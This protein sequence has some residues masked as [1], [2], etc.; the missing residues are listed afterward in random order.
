MTRTRVK[1]LGHSIPARVGLAGL[2]SACLALYAL[3]GAVGVVLGRRSR[4]NGGPYH[5]LVVGT[6]YT[7]NWCISHLAPLAAARNVRRVTAI[8]EGPI[9]PIAN[10]D[11]VQP[12]GWP[13]RLGGRAFGKFCCAIRLALKHRPDVV[14]GYHIVPNALIALVAARAVGAAS[15]Y[16]MTAGPVELLGGGWATENVFVRHLRRPSLVIDRLIH[17]IARCFDLVIVRG[18]GAANYARTHRLGRAISTIPGSIDVRRFAP[19]GEKR[20]YDLVSVG[21][22]VSVKQPEQTLRVVAILKETFP[23]VR[24]IV[25]G[26]GPLLEPLKAQAQSLGLVENIEFAGH[27][28]DVERILKRSKIFLLTSRSEGLSIALAEAMSAGAVPVVARVGELGDLVRDGVNGWLVTPDA[29]AE[30]AERIRT[31]LDSPADLARCSAAAAN[32]AHEHNGLES[33]AE[34]WTRALADACGRPADCPSP[35]N[36]V[37]PVSLNPAAHK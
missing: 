9:Q 3:L 26:D 18:H 30:Y 29:I 10:V 37:G 24:A 17:A 20:E 23:S 36:T 11:Y 35:S 22:L 6:F 14:M 32:A 1:C 7:R 21:R 28:D 31:L 12:S 16:Q 33:I 15:A 2:Y 8:V 34:R 13:V 4:A 27:V 5:V 25:V 19:R